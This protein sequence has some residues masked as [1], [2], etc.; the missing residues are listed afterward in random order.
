MTG[1]TARPNWSKPMFTPS[2]SACAR[3]GRIAAMIVKAPF[4]MPEDP[5]PA[6]AL[7]TMSSADDWATPQSKEPSSNM[8]KKVRKVH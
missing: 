1:P 4:E 6:I 3:G 5:A 2:T 8:R 7:P